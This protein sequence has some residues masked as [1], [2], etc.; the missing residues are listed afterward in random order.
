MYEE[1]FKTKKAFQNLFLAFYEK[2]VF[3]RNDL[4]DSE[5]SIIAKANR[6]ISEKEI[7]LASDGLVSISD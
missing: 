3:A 7:T 4:Y 6:E 5:D 2:K 1:F